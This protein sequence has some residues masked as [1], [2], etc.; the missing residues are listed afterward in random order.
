MAR[1]LSRARLHR[2]EDFKAALEQGR[3][4]GTGLLSAAVRHN[5]LG[6]PR[7]G[8]ALAKKNIAL[9]TMRNR[10]KRHIRESFREHQAA[11]PSADIV[12]FA[13]A[14]AARATQADL[15]AALEQLWQR[16][17]QACA[18]SPSF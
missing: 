6:I 1:L 3:R 4:V 15:H 5:G 14:S 2:P 12:V 7:L 9:A 11:L 13:K 16:V 18:T 10:I 17:N 8:L